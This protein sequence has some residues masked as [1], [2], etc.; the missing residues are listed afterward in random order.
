M[1]GI[2]KLAVKLTS[3]TLVAGLL[4]GGTYVLT[5]GPIEKQELEK[6]TAARQAVLAAESFEQMDMSAVTEE[7]FA[8]ISEIYIGRDAAGNT[9]G[10]TLKMTAKGFKPGMVITVGIAADGTVS[11]VDIGDNEET[12]GL[13]AKATEE[14]FYGQYAG[15]K[16]DS[17]LSVV[18]NTEP[19]DG[20]I[21]A[22]AGA[23]ITSRGVTKAVNTAVACYKAHVAG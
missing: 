12:P 7:E 6:A 5:K 10:A 4:L 19:A 23:T 14:T 3:I 18:K 9:V 11:G 8:D 13:G 21:L 1:N 22:I 17:E 16:T 15:Q 20:E 2:L